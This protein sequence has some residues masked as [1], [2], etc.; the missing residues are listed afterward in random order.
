MEEVPEESKTGA[1]RKPHRHGKKRAGGDPHGVELT[2]RHSAKQENNNN[3]PETPEVQA[4][5]KR[6][7]VRRALIMK[8]DLEKTGGAAEFC[9]KVNKLDRF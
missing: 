9:Q 4:E 2:Q 5:R 8:N 1:A 7:L 3:A 6:K